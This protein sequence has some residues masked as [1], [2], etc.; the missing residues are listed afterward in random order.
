MKKQTKSGKIRL[1]TL[2]MHAVYDGRGR[3]RRHAAYIHSEALLKQFLVSTIC[4]WSLVIC[5]V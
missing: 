2:S 4:S 1:N 3:R 5:G